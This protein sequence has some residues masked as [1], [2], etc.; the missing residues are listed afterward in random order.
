MRTSRGWA[1]EFQEGTP[2]TGLADRK[3]PRTKNATVVTILLPEGLSDADVAAGDA[4]TLGVPIRG[5]NGALRKVYLGVGERARLSAR[6]NINEYT[7][8]FPHGTNITE[9]FNKP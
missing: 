5:S 6:I 9:I 4:G 7:L 8:E 1:G 3:I 2:G